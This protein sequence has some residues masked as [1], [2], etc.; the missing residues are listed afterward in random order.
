MKKTF[1]YSLIVFVIAALLPSIALGETP[2]TGSQFPFSSGGGKASVNFEIRA[3]ENSPQLGWKKQKDSS[4]ADIYISPTVDIANDMIDRTGVEKGSFSASPTYEVK[5]L[6]NEKGKEAFSILTRDRI[7]KHIAIL[8][9][10]RV[11][12]APRVYEQISSGRVVIPFFSD[13]TEA[14]RV[15]RGIVGN[16]GNN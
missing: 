13:S 5:I 6:F 16:W 15:A 8:V 7:N 3:V 9:D 12:S 14:E 1:G 11:L 10:G 2:S 4:G